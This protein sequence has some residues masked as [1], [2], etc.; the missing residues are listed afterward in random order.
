MPRHYRLTARSL[1]VKRPS[2]ISEAASAY[3]VT[4]AGLLIFAGL[5]A[6]LWSLP[7]EAQS[8]AP[9]TVA[10]IPSPSTLAS[11]VSA[12]QG[13][14]AESANVASPFVPPTEVA[15]DASVAADDA[16]APISTVASRELPEAALA[17]P[18]AM[19]ERETELAEDVE[20]RS[21]P[22]YVLGGTWAPNRAACDKQVAARTGWLPMKISDRGA[23][24]GQTTCSFRKLVGSGSEWTAV[25]ECLGPR[26]HWTSKVR[27]QVA[28]SSLTWSSERGVRRYVRCDRVQV[29]S[30]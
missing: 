20:P 26:G 16:A 12:E 28:A 13:E 23:H 5:N 27:L 17:E 1:P 3:P 22:R 6:F 14:A 10:S 18:E 19:D 29:A 24:A 7:F 30:R 2:R 11:G 21:A 8:P 4:A 25:A 15:Q 9:A